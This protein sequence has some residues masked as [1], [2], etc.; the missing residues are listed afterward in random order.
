MRFLVVDD[1]GAL[2]AFLIRAL[3]ADGHHVQFAGD[4]QA[5]VDMFL[6]QAPDLTILELNLPRRDGVDVLRFLRSITADSPVLILTARS[7]METRVKCLDLGA[8]DY[9]LKPFALVELRARCRV[10]LRRR[11]DPNLILR[12]RDLEVNRVERSVVRHG[13]PVALTNKEF[14]LLEYLLLNRG[15]AV[16]RSALLEHVWDMRVTSTNVVDVYVNYLRR[17]LGDA[18]AA[19]LIQT[20]RGEGYAIGLHH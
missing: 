2:G 4:G 16:S 3:E 15:H 6:K 18:G 14:A 5:A 10:L 17:K 8:D 13:Q 19:P 7:D 9:M 1:D 11:R 20:I 12:Q